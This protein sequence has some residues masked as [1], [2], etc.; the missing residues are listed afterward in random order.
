MTLSASVDVAGALHFTR[1]AVFLSRCA[2]RNRDPRS[3][4]RARKSSI[5]TASDLL[6]GVMQTT[7][8]CKLCRPV[9]GD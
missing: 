6:F 4:F 2:A 7:G 1:A 5:N 9:A 8:F 3:K